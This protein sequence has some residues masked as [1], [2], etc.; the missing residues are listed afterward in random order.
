MYV[1]KQLSKSQAD[2]LVE[3]EGQ[4]LYLSEVPNGMSLLESRMNKIAAKADRIN[5]MTDHIEAM[6]AYELM[7]TVETLKDK[8]TIAGGFDRGDNSMSSVA[9]M[10]ECIE[11]LDNAQQDIIQMV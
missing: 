3:I 1:A 5:E 6:S 9:Q 7:V 11:G 2:Q 8:V 10:E 4:L